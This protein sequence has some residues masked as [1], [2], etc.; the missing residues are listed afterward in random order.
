MFAFSIALIVIIINIALRDIKNLRSVT[1]NLASGKSNLTKR[2][3][4]KTNDISNT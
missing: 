2:L 1:E 3:S 4:V